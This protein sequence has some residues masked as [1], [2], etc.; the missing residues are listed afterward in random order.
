MAV[1]GHADFE[2]LAGAYFSCQLE[3]DQVAV[4]APGLQFAGQP[5][6]NATAPSVEACAQLCHGSADT[7]DLFNFVGGGAQGGN[8]SCTL[9]SMG[10]TI[11]P[12]VASPPA[13]VASSALTA[14][15]PVRERLVVLPGFTAQAGQGVPGADLQCN[16]TVIPG[17]CAIN[18]VLDAVVLCTRVQDCEAVVH[19]P[20]G[21]DG[22]SEPVTLLVHDG[23]TQSGA[24]MSPKVDTLSRVD[25][26]SLKDTTLMAP[27]GVV[28][29]PAEVEP[30][31][32]AAADGS[33]GN[34]TYYGCIVANNV[35]LSGVPVTVLDGAATAE[36]CCRMCRS[37]TQCQLFQYCD[38]PAGCS[39][40]YGPYAIE[41]KH[42]QCKLLSSSAV[43]LPIG[44]PPAVVERGP[45]VPFVGGLPLAFLP[46][47]LPGFERLPGRNQFAY[48][49]GS[50]TCPFSVNFQ[51]LECVVAGTPQEVAQTCSQLEQC[52]G[53]IVSPGQEP[54][55]VTA[56]LKSNIDN[57]SIGLSPTNALYL[58]EAVNS[59][60]VGGGGGG[61][62]SSSSSSSGL[63]SGAI[64]GIAVGA[65][66][67]VAAAA[68]AAWL[69][70]RRR[71]RC[72]LGSGPSLGEGQLK[73]QMEC[74]VV[75]GG[76]LGGDGDGGIPPIGSAPPSG[77][78]VASALTQSS[79][80]A[81]GCTGA[82]S[83]G[84]GAAPQ[85]AA[86]RSV[87]HPATVLPASSA[88]LGGPY[89]S[90]ATG[91]RSVA[92]AGTPTAASPFVAMRA[93]TTA[94]PSAP[95]SIS[96]GDQQGVTSPPRS[97]DSSGAQSIPSGLMSGMSSGAG[98]D[99]GSGSQSHMMLPELAAH[100]AQWDADQQGSEQ[101]CVVGGELHTEQSL[102]ASGTLSKSLQ[103]W[104]V[105][106]GEIEYLRWP[107][108]RLQELGR[109]ASGVVYKARF[110]GETVAAKEVDLGR[111][112]SVQSLFVTEAERLHQLRHANIVTLYGVC[113]AG[114][115]GILLME[116]A[117]GR[118]LHSA[119][120][121]RRQGTNERLFGWYGRGRIV[122]YDLSRA[123][124]ALHA[125]GVAHLD[126]K[127]SNVLL[128]GSG[129]AKLADVGAAHIQRGTY[130]S[131]LPAGSVGTFAWMA[132]EMMLGQKCTKAADLFSFGVVLWEIATGEAPQRGSMRL[133]R[134]PEECP[135]E[136]AD[137]IERCMRLE[138]AERPTAQQLMLQLEE[139]LA[140]LPAVAAAA[141][142]DAAEEAA[143]MRQLRAAA[144]TAAHGRPAPCATAIGMAGWRAED[145]IHHCRWARVACDERQR[146]KH[147]ELGKAAVV[148][149]MSGAA[150]GSPSG[151][152][153]GGGGG[154]SVADGNTASL[155]VL[156]P[157]LARLPELTRL[158]LEECDLSG[159]SIPSEWGQP[160]AFPSLTRL[161]LRSP[162]FGGP[163]LPDIAPGALP[164]LRVLEISLIGNA[165]SF[166]PTLPPS[167]GAAPD[168]LPSLQQLVLQLPITGPLPPQWARGFAHLW[169]LWLSSQVVAGDGAPDLDSC[170]QLAATAAG[171]PERSLPA[172]WAEGFPALQHLELN[173][174]RIGGSLPEAWV[175]GGFPNLSAMRLA[176][177]YLTGSLPPH[178][179]SAHPSLTTL[180]LDGNRLSGTLPAE[181]AGSRARSLVL[182]GNALHGPA[183]PA[184][185][186]RPGAF[187][188]LAKLSVG[189]NSQ[190]TGSLPE[191]LGWDAIVELHLQDT[192]L[193][194]TV[195]ST[196]C[197]Q[198][199]VQ[200]L[201]SLQIWGT[202]I[203]PQLPR[204]FSERPKLRVFCQRPA[205]DGWL[206][207]DVAAIRSS[208]GSNSSSGSSTLQLL[209]RQWGL[210]TDSLRL[211]PG[212]LELTKG[213][214][215]LPL[216][217]GEGAHAV[218]MLGQLQGME[219]AVK[220]FE[221]ADGAASHRMWREVALLRDCVHER[222][223]PLYGVAMSG[224]ML[225]LVQRLMHGGSLQQALQQPGKREA[226]RWEAGGW[227]VALDIA[228]GLA[229]LH[230]RQTLHADLKSSNVLLSH[231]LRAYLADLSMSRVLEGTACT[232]RGGTACYA[233]P[234]QL[235]GERC[236][237]AADIYSLGVLL[238]ELINREPVVRRGGWSLPSPTECPVAVVDLIGACLAADPAQ[239]PS[240]ADVVQRLREC[241]RR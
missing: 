50:F 221:P 175:A 229:F 14:G 145:N 114:P 7:C 34:Q 199:M 147:I 65:A 198:P 43:A 183:F 217:I 2:Q 148:T 74:V 188:Q 73:D 129:T 20:N 173:C 203:S 45:A 51:S 106:V 57:S 171:A 184:A 27:D 207:Q 215:G 35:L 154:G 164:A 69:F 17:K 82:T 230:A 178:I 159:S 28:L 228:E 108:G 62:S 201:Q 142:A 113:L 218:V 119:L 168:V 18:S 54:G 40:Q 206:D 3:Q 8:G 11:A 156:L 32:G 189:G 117:A 185:W 139:L 186:L 236:T 55:K 5:V 56:V 234:E 196:W 136:V 46:P 116:Y 208:S 19:Y 13:G 233:A 30:G 77:G 44:F 231:S 68:A 133:P 23:L 60:A 180:E 112:S 85:A 174:L 177:N 144:V 170:R 83:D 162:G 16:Q 137:L 87:T 167:W 102:L 146:V 182:E 190:L 223:V 91:V 70:V 105:D 150:V 103:D 138:V 195:P 219:V 36:A 205:L 151:G 125:K 49:G 240:A 1:P 92:A 237:L 76:K 176:Y 157:G 67:A 53:F 41:L 241:E 152:G 31:S 169:M 120:Q 111:S 80:A 220:V 141:L 9:L 99:Y 131:E 71:R 193:A 149:A 216:V 38:L 165:S 97:Y 64:A 210:G 107:D 197:R 202:D 121:V 126:I 226:L 79:M 181:Y 93:R 21:T 33:T 10:C 75:A 58:L 194:G 52:T 187:A 192:G 140:L 84:A 109:G 88:A 204:C 134:V 96:G 81:S 48:S 104:L 239:R 123:L 124:N 115:I 12:T 127:S 15:F 4:F 63:S 212:E 155:S 22:C 179:F 122:A 24:F 118:D 132:P 98:T 25:S 42:Q 191:L 158:V 161:T 78:T 227:R 225:L 86:L 101:Q 209:S 214:D 66:A 135:Q 172:A 143:V 166:R 110:R 160:G 72:V 213:A 211:H 163:Q 89:P 26:N 61:G 90:A 200:S 232:A 224:N 59:S 238:C 39:F 6:R 222:L 94:V 95:V 100:V 37:N 128:T 235:L 153:G 47:E 29:L 130:L